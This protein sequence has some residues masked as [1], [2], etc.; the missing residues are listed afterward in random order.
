M[1]TLKDKTAQGL[2]WGMMNNGVMQLFNIIFGI[3]L[4]RKLSDGDYGLA[5]ELAIFTAIASALQESGFI[6]ALTN[7]KNAT[8]LDY[9]SVFW[10]NV[11]VSAAIYVILFFCAPTTF[12]IFIMSV[13]GGLQ[14]GFDFAKI[15][16]NGGPAGTTTTLAYYIYTAGFEELRFG[17]ASAVAWTMFVMIFVMTMINWKYGNRKMEM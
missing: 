4:A 1:A 6:S 12:F 16:T 10:F 3:I 11:A 13:I 5:G 2:L 9:D 17:F 15:M 14:G 8:K 7:R